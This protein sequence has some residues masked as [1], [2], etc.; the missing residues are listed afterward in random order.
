MR[1][2]CTQR[3]LSDNL[4]PELLKLKTPVIVCGQS[5]CGKKTTIERGLTLAG[6]LVTV[7]SADVL[8]F[9]NQKLL[10][11]MNGPQLHKGAVLVTGVE[12]LQGTAALM[13]FVEVC[14]KLKRPMFAT[15]TNDKVTKHRDVAKHCHVC[16]V[17]GTIDHR[18]KMQEDFL[19]G[20]G[21]KDLLDTDLLVGVQQLFRNPTLKNTTGLHERLMDDVT[22]TSCTVFENYI[23]L[24]DDLTAAA[25]AVDL[26]SLADNMAADI[27]AQHR[28]D[29]NEH[30]FY[31]GTVAPAVKVSP[32]K[33][34]DLKISSV[35]SKISMIRGKQNK[36][37][38][39]T[40]KL[41]PHT[42]DHDYLHCLKHLIKHSPEVLA[43]LTRNG[44]TYEDFHFC[45]KLFNPVLTSSELAKLK[46]KLKASQPKRKASQPP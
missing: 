29:L 20:A 15:V 13:H 34:R 28:Y 36:H 4:V 11:D 6:Y 2:S 26:L 17:T 42:V 22:T 32:V 18:A 43:Q 31:A 46:T 44:L 45:A 30:F 38:A 7:I 8:A 33:N 1:Q 14:A 37:A 24:T 23:T 9:T 19:P 35:W 40:A 39:L 3:P 41:A 12:A 5:G 21:A 16:H 27:H 10:E 25:A